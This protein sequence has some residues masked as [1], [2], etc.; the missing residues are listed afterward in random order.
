MWVFSVPSESVNTWERKH[1]R[2][3]QQRL[4]SEAEYAP[5]ARIY[6]RK[7][8]G[9]NSGIVEHSINR[10]IRFWSFMTWDLS[11]CAKSC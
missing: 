11:C 9:V 6:Q 10:L 1:A 7:K 4:I 2:Y 8:L 3:I 5:S